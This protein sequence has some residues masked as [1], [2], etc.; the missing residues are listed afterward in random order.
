MARYSVLLELEDF[1]P[2]LVASLKRLQL[3]CCVGQLGKL[4]PIGNRPVR[5]V[6]AAGH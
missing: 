1:I 4:R 5:T 3:G 2:A 6:I